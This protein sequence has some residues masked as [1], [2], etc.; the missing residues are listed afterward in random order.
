M[1]LNFNKGLFEAF[2]A[3]TG[4]K[5]L[6][7]SKTTA[8]SGKATQLQTRLSTYLPPDPAP[9]VPSTEVLPNETKVSNCI[10]ALNNYGQG[11][12]TL[13]AHVDAR[14][15]TFLDDMNVAAAVKQIDSYINEVPAS[16]TNINSLAGTLS[17]ATDSLLTSGSE[18]LDELD[19]GIT[20]YDAD[21]LSLEAFEA[22]LDK[23]TSQLASSLSGILGMIS[24]EASMLEDMYQTHKQ[25]AKAFGFTALLNDEC[26]RPLL[27]QLAGP[28]VSQVLVSDFKVGNLLE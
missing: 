21:I 25:M 4:F 12:N 9:A 24:N 19:Q 10:E 23:V 6:T 7:T 27:V 15:E 26:I 8:I 20:D 28:E 1:S 16:C 5:N 13:N 22:L 11:A 17:G 3:G 2:G 14:L 18:L